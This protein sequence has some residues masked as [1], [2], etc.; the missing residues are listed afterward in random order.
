MGK[1]NKHNFAVDIT[2]MIH[3]YN[4]RIKYWKTGI[5]TYQRLESLRYNVALAI[6]S[7]LG[8]TSKEN[9]YNEVGLKSLQNRG[10]YRKLSFLYKLLLTNPLLIFLT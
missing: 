1:A 3:E 10:W 8:G 9:L 2:K 6:K 7:A 5:W 4:G